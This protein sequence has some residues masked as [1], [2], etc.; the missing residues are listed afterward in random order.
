MSDS[1]DLEDFYESDA[2]AFFNQDGA[3]EEYEE[4]DDEEDEEVDDEEVEEERFINAIE[5]EE[6]Q[7]LLNPENTIDYDKDSFIDENIDYDQIRSS[8][9]NDLAD[10][11]VGHDYLVNY[12]PPRMVENIVRDYG[13]GMVMKLLAQH[14]EFGLDHHD[15]RT[16]MNDNN[17]NNNDVNPYTVFKEMKVLC[18][19]MLPLDFLFLKK[20]LRLSIL[21]ISITLELALLVE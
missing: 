13:P 15:V 11:S 12:F 3:D 10:M 6:I 8:I 5:E 19:I 21:T 14:P 4:V 2:E 20:L 9:I 16:I 7:R 1:D 17:N 18:L